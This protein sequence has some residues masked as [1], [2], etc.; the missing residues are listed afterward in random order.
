LTVARSKKPS[1]RGDKAAAKAAKPKVARP[2]VVEPAAEAATGWEPYEET[3]ELQIPVDIVKRI[4]GHGF[5]L[6][7]HARTASGKLQIQRIRYRNGK[8]QWS[9]VRVG[10]FGGLLDSLA[11]PGSK[12][13]DPIVVGETGNELVLEARPVAIQKQARAFDKRAAEEPVRMID[14]K[15]RSEGVDVS[16]PGG[17][18]HPTALRN[19]RVNRSWEQIPVPTPS[20]QTEGA[21]DSE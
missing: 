6:E 8:G 16:M 13:G 10:D 9:P 4:E 1:L 11:A 3:S 20:Y 2:Q 17:G 14:F 7:W 19:N 18:K 12:D 21:P 15:Y 5:S